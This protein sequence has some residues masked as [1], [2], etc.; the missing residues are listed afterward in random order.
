MV[1]GVSTTIADPIGPE[2]A[3]RE[4]KEAV[5]ASSKMPA[6]ATN[7]LRSGAPGN[8]AR[9]AEELNM[10]RKIMAGLLAAVAIALAATMA[11]VAHAPRPGVGP[12]DFDRLR[13]GMS[14]A[15]AE[16]ILHGPPRNDL[17]H[18]ALIWMPRADAG[19]VSAR[20]GPASP[21]VAILIREDRP[22]EAGSRPLTSTADDF[23]PGAGAGR[24]GQGVWVSPA[25]LVAVLFDQ[26][27]R[28]AERYFSTV[29]ETKPPTLG[30]WL[31][32]RPA[33]IRRSLGF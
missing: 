17:A 32:S 24:G 27:G 25:G 12:G 5:A 21:A 26:D 11:L 31:A 6:T 22:R 14:R 9:P 15:E 29:D 30:G 1:A 33:A 8:L 4:I 19:K 23:F 3:S 18:P 10:N 13:V 2:I 7:T 28:V 20:F 16:A